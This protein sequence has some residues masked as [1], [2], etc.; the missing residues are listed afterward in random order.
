[1]YVFYSFSF[2]WVYILTHCCP[3][4]AGCGGRKEFFEYCEQALLEETA[5]SK[6]RR[7][8]MRYSKKIQTNHP[9]RLSDDR[10]RDSL[11]AQGI[12]DA[13]ITQ[14]LIEAQRKILAA[15]MRHHSRPKKVKHLIPGD[16]D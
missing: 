16:Y 3:A 2:S 5:A 14:E 11:N 13:W 9:A 15:R 7:R 4:K 10:V 6:S 1:M 8:Y 12:C